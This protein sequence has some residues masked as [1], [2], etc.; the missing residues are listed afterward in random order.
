MGFV[1]PKDVDNHPVR[2]LDRARQREL[3]WWVLGVGVFVGGLLLLAWQRNQW[4]TI[5]YG[6]DELKKAAAVEETTHRDLLVE[7]ATLR[8]PQRIEE[9]ATTQLHM[10]APTRTEAVVIE[11]V[12][13]AAAPAKTLVARR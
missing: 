7:A 8:S 1:V 10:V 9:I 13:Q 11:R 12:R 6:M 5:G 2:E 4:T 3:W